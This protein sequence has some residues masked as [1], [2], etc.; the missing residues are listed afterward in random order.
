LGF[1]LLGTLL[2]RAASARLDELA[3]REVLAPLGV[4]ARFVDEH[5]AWRPSPV[6]P[7]EIMPGRGLV[8]GEVHDENCHAAGGVGGH[9][10]LF[11]TADDLSTFA[12]AMVASWHG[13]DVAGGF[14]SDV[15]RRFLAPAGVPGST[16]R[17]GWDGPAAEGSRIGDRWAKDGSLAFGFTGCS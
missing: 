9:A 14:G 11:A 15:V 7:T 4:G 13:R 10:G 12:A 17:L 5:A 16:W 1:I 8:C 6:A 2:E 3:A